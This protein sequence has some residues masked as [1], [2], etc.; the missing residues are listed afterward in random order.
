MR[1]QRLWKARSNRCQMLWCQTHSAR[2]PELTRAHP[3]SSPQARHAPLH[4]LQMRRCLLCSHMLP[5]PHSLQRARRRLCTQIPPRLPPHSVQLYLSLPARGQSGDFARGL[6]PG[7]GQTQSKATSTPVVN[8]NPAAAPG[9]ALLAG[10]L[11]M[12]VLADATA[13][14]VPAPPLL[15]PVL[16]PALARRPLISALL[17]HTRSVTDNVA[18]PNSAPWMRRGACIG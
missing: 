7:P 9:V 11:D 6:S 14:T 2:S 17:T 8:A 13:T 5:P 12:V 10:E 1:E 3:R 15:A 18:L 4:S 16:A